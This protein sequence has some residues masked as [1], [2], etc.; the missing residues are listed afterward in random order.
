MSGGVV[1]GATGR[2]GAAGRGDGGS[3]GR[4]CAGTT[5]APDWTAASASAAVGSNAEVRAT[6]AMLPG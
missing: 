5:G 3:R 6:A 2:S 4:T 1:T